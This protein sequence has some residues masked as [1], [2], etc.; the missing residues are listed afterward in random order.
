MDQAKQKWKQNDGL[1]RRENNMSDKEKE[2][3]KF[4]NFMDQMHKKQ[5]AA[6]PDG[7]AFARR[8]F[9]NRL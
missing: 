4:Y 9:Q 5:N 6:G 2:E 8:M 1:T 7:L 3:L